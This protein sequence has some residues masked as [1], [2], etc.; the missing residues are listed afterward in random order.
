MY[1]DRLALARELMED[2]ST[3]TARAVDAA[4]AAVNQAR[5]MLAAAYKALDAANHAHSIDC[6]DQADAARAALFSAE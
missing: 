5:A 6:L 3:P 1:F 2:T 4:A